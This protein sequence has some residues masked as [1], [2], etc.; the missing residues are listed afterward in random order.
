MQIGTIL[1]IFKESIAERDLFPF[2]PNFY[3]YLATQRIEVPI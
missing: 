2:L 3:N 1:E